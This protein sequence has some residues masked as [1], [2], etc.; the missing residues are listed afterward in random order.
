M[1]NEI[2]VGLDDSP[3]SIAA[4]N[5]AAEQATKLDAPLRAVHVLDWPYGLSAAGFPAPADFMDVS[6]EELQES[7]RRAITA[8]FD[9]VSPRPGWELQF[10]SGDTGRVLVQ[11]SKD[12]RLLVVGTRE[13]VGLGRLLSGSVSH[14]CLS[15]AA[16][17]VVAVPAP[18][19][20]Q[21]GED[22]EMVGQETTVVVEEDLEA[23]I[24]VVEEMTDETETP[25]TPL[26]VVGV[27]ASA[28]A[29]AAA[30]YAVT[31]AE[32]RGGD[33]LMVHAF[34][35]LSARVGDRE[36][37]LSAR[38]TAEKLLAAVAA[39]LIVP[40]QLHVYG[41]AEPGNAVGVLEESAG[42]AAMLVLGRDNVSWGERLLMGAVT[43]QVVTHIA[44]PLVV[45]PRRWRPRH[46][47]PRLPVIVA[48]D[49]ETPPE[50]A[51]KLGFEEATLRDARLIVLHAKPMSAS[52]SD[53]AAA[54]F[55]LDTVLAEWEQDHL[56]VAISTVIVSGD[57][58]AQL[59]RWSRSAAVLVVGHPH[60]R[61]F[62]SW[63]RSVARSVMKQ[64]HCPLIVAPEATAEADGR[65]ELAEQ[66]LP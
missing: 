32:L 66:A 50:P 60:Q 12:A 24:P 33:V 29:L 57:P 5:W 30:H 64:T 21:I 14:Y 55:D 35:S 16:C 27:D 3:S 52:A 17:P 6:R 7:Y 18:V 65:R 13:H 19:S 62:G 38:T 11:Q 42:R 22:S 59:V 34:P 15:H 54:G 43:S 10:A 47:W 48:L 45:V 2:V 25:G 56:D 49:G 44:C 28:E 31:A 46:A 58:D 1:R 8:V 37:A 53:L 26:V 61:R 23:A 4:L 36:A 51:L 39:Q 40:P 9:A 41:R 20:D 63:T